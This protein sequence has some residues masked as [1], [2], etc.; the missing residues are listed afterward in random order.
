MDHHEKR[1]W[2]R[3]EVHRAL[4]LRSGK[5]PSRAYTAI[6]LDVA[7]ENIGIETVAILELGERIQL[8]LEGQDKTIVSTSRC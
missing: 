2:G 3:I 1:Q 5:D 8:E 4:T 6:A 7:E